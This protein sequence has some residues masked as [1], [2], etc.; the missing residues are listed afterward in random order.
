MGSATG[1][2]GEAAG[3]VGSRSNAGGEWSSS[4]SERSIECRG[5][6]QPPTQLEETLMKGL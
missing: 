4:G 1:G 3:V 5:E 6:P 2:G